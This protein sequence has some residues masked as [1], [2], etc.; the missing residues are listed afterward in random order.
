LLLFKVKNPQTLIIPFRI[1]FRTFIIGI[2]E[3]KT[4]AGS[5]A[6][7]LHADVKS[8]VPAAVT[9]FFSVFTSKRGFLKFAK[10]NQGFSKFFFFK[11]IGFLSFFV[12]KLEKINFP[13]SK[14]GVVPLPPLQQLLVP[15]LGSS[16]LIEAIK[17]NDFK[18]I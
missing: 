14:F 1:I 16:N 5:P 12:R 6:Y 8:N 15:V 11:K 18:M 2:G 3:T 4:G 13:Y 7:S 17:C 10:K 9:V